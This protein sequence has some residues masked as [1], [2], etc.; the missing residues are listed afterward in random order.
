M[1]GHHGI[2]QTCAAIRQKM[3]EFLRGVQILLHLAPPNHKPLAIKH[4]QRSTVNGQRLTV[5]GQWSLGNGQWSM[6]NGQWSMVGYFQ[7]VVGFRLLSMTVL[8]INPNPAFSVSSEFQEREANP[9]PPPWWGGRAS[10]RARR[11]LAL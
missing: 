9:V 1:C 3:V 11:Q 2:V 8:S 10:P 5:N 4:G 6:V 7:I